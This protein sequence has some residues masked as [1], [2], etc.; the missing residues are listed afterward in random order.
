[1]SATDWTQF[2]LPEDSATEVTLAIAGSMKPYLLYW[3]DREKKIDET[4]PEFVLRHVITHA[5]LMRK[6]TLQYSANRDQQSEY[7]EYVEKMEADCAAET[8]RLVG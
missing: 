3:Y 6:Q 7:N 2:T 5:L 1:M 4:V 8:T